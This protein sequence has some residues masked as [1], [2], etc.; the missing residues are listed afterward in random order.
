MK[1]H[2]PILAFAGPSGAGKTRLL[3]RLLPALRA[4]GLTVAALKHTG[5]SHP[6]DARGKDT[7]R[8]RRAGAVAAAILGPAGLALFGPPVRSAREL[9]RLLPPCDLVVAEGFKSE[10]LPRVEVHRRRVD[11]AFLCAGDARVIAVVGDEAPPRPLPCFA[12]GDVEAL[13]DFVVAFARGGRRRISAGRRDHRPR[14]AAA[15]GLTPF[16]GGG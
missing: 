15:R 3:V 14:R 7:E 6:F 9:A 12:P 13:A 4:R 16:P 2:P 1:R 10:A 11:R 8:L 5:H